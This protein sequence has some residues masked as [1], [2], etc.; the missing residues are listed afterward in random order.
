[1]SPEQIKEIK[2]NH[3]ELF[4]V[5]RAVLGSDKSAASVIARQIEHDAANPPRIGAAMKARD[6]TDY[7]NALLQ[8][9]FGARTGA[10]LLR[11]AA[12]ALDPEAE[13]PELASPGNVNVADVEELIAGYRAQNAKDAHS[14]A[15]LKGELQAAQDLLEDDS[16][17]AERALLIKLRACSNIKE[18]RDVFAAFDAD[19]A[20]E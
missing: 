14:I 6:A 7:A 13:L 1:M 16:Q 2:V 8:M 4:D 10:E 5:K 12:L 17:D 18:V 3:R 15:A 19:A 11:T 9:F 20:G